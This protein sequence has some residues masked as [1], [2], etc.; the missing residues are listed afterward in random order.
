MKMNAV[1]TVRLLIVS[2]DSAVLHLMWS[3]GES[4]CWQIETAANA[5]E[6]MDK[7]Q[8]GVSLDLLL[9]DLPPGN[10]EALHTLRRLRR[11]RPMLPVI[12]IGHASDV[13]RQQEALRIG[14]S[15]YLMRPIEEHELAAVIQ[16]NLS[17]WCEAAET[18]ITSDDVEMIGNGRFFIGISAIMRKLRTQAASLADADVPVLILGEEGSG[19]ET[20]ARLIHHLSVR[21]GFDFAKVACAA[22][23]GELLEKELLG[24]ERE[25]TI[26]PA[27]SKSGKLELCAKGT[28]LLDEITEMPLSLQS[29]L[30]DV[31]Q[32]KR[33]TRPRTSNA[34]EADVR[35][36]AASSADLERAVSEDK[37][38]ENLYSYLTGYT[39]HIPPLRE[40]R[41]EIPFLARHF[42]HRLATQ[43]GLPPREY[44]PAILGAWQAYNWPGNLLELECFVKRYLMVG[45]KELD[46]GKSPPHFGSAAQSAVPSRPRSIGHPAPAS[47]Q[48]S[49]TVPGPNSLRSLIQSVK[50]EA[51][52][53]AIAVALEKTGW[54]RKAAARLLNV[55]YRT[56]LYKIEQYKMTAY[57]TSTHAGANGNRKGS[58]SVETTTGASGPEELANL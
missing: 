47:I 2:S 3:I 33:F 19:K 25:N 7:I 52:K 34:I 20:I 35:V 46:F 49:A 13:G 6:A 58:S 54:N 31:L 41:E 4:N 45:D 22:L 36:L 44:S 43:Y 26:A 38:D 57:D 32:N 21:S 42:M 15:D 27:Q 17:K 53:N 28:I 30:L 40:R 48:S 29:N 9:L 5:W 12:L 55:S 1:A 8:S 56:V 10:G 51:E 50:S 18:D 23:P 11:L 16:R 39:I 24:Y 14:I 37:F